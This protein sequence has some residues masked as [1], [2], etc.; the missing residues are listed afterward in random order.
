MTDPRLE[1]LAVAARNAREKSG[2]SQRA[3]AEAV[4]WTDTK[5]LNIEKA[6]I[7]KIPPLE[8]LQALDELYATDGQLARLAGYTP[9]S[10]DTRQLLRDV[11]EKHVS[12]LMDDVLK[13][14][15]R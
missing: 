5:V 13:L 14:Y 2:L 9:V 4:G 3:V 10:D 6:K 8:D 12:A 7:R 1:R 15:G 11:V